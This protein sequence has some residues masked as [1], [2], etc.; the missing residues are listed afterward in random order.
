MRRK[1]TE[2]TNISFST[3]TFGCQY[4]FGGQIY[5][6]V[7]VVTKMASNSSVIPPS[8]PS[9]TADIC[10]V[11]HRI[12][13]LHKLMFSETAVWLA[14]FFFPADK[15]KNLLIQYCNFHILTT[16]FHLKLS[17]LGIEEHPLQWKKVYGGL[18][19]VVF[20]FCLYTATRAVECRTESIK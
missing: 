17:P 15:K 8:C 6:E 9:I 5:L 3:Q 10:F 18:F 16:L 12:E 1:K 4:I 14:F 19:V 7:M 20:F 2:K 11:V 13:A